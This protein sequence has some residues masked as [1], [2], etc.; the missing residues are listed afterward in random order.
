MIIIVS[1]TFQMRCLCVFGFR[2]HRDATLCQQHCV[3]WLEKVSWRWVAFEL[4]LEGFGKVDKRVG[5]F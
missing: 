5:A 3:V 1:A 4:Y 2:L